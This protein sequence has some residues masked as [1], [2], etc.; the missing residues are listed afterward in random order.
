MSKLNFIYIGKDWDGNP[1]NNLPTGDITAIKV[2]F[3]DDEFHYVPIIPSSYETVD[4]VK[5]VFVCGHG[6]IKIGKRKKFLIPT[7]DGTIEH[8]KEYIEKWG[9]DIMCYCLN[10]D[11]F[12]RSMD[13]CSINYIN[14]YRCLKYYGPEKYNDF[15]THFSSMLEH[16]KKWFDEHH[17]PAFMA[18]G[19][20]QKITKNW[21]FKPDLNLGFSFMPIP[22]MMVDIL[23][24]DKMLEEL[25]KKLRYWE[26]YQKH[27]L[28]PE[29]QKRQKDMDDYRGERSYA[30]MRWDNGFEDLC[31]KRHEIDHIIHKDV[32]KQ[33]KEELELEYGTP[34]FPQ[35]FEDRVRILFG[36]DVRREYDYLCREFDCEDNKKN[37]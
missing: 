13:C 15:A 28:Y 7:F 11:N 9:D 34:E 32:E 19:Y 33:I 14:E 8:F 22:T 12:N 30:D 24:D 10:G 20:G 26:L 2:K 6:W 35:C 36:P 29:Y 27:E 37:V 16:Q 5:E 25:Y 1:K 4:Q 31:E 23:H 18:H 21:L 17:L 3:D